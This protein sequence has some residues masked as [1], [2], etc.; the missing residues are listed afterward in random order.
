MPRPCRPC[1]ARRPRPDEVETLARQQLVG[2]EH[3]AVQRA[4]VLAEPLSYVRQC[5]DARVDHRHIAAETDE[6]ISPAAVSAPRV[7]DAP[8]AKPF[9]LDG[10]LL[11][12]DDALDLRTEARV[13][14]SQSPV[15]SEP[16][17]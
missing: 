5:V 3:V 17:W 4:H 10:Q 15:G 9:R 12:A 2:L 1:D 8:A 13:S 16:H 6:S 7:E 14:E 11:L